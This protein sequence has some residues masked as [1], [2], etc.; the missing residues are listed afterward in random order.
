MWGSYRSEIGAGGDYILIKGYNGTG[1]NPYHTFDILELRL[2]GTTLLKGY[3]NQVLISVN[4]MGEPKV[5]MDAALLYKGVAGQLAVAVAKVPD[6]AFANW[7][8]SLA[9]RKGP[10]EWQNSF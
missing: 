3:H 10:S 7:Q 5:A 8:R 9:L 4:G 1:R 2:N 6:L